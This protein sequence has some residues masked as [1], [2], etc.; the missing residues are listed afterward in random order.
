MLLEYGHAR[1]KWG[2]ETYNL[3]PS[4]SNIAK[5]GK[6]KEIIDLFKSFIAIGTYDITRFSIALDVINSCSDKPIPESLTGSVVFS[7]RKCKRL[8]KMPNHG[9]PMF[10]DV[11]TLARHCLIHGICG[12]VDRDGDDN[13]EPVQ[14]FDA[15]MFM[16]MARIH[17]EVNAHEASQ[18]TM[19]EFARLM[20]A[21]YPQEKAKKNESKKVISEFDE[22]LR[23]GEEQDA[24]G[25]H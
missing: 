1:I 8:Y 12:N 14:E 18:M 6:P 15:Y 24:K 2:G 23:W 20:D 10:D 22:L 4:F 17:L 19:T 5:L 13:A 9:L 21:K 16:E 7:E 11:I 3:T 25:V